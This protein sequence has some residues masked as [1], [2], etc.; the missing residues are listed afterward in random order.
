MCGCSLLKCANLCS[1]PDWMKV[2]VCENKKNNNRLKKIGGVTK[3]LRNW[4]GRRKYLINLFMNEKNEWFVNI[5]KAKKEWCIKIITD[6]IVVW[7]FCFVKV[8]PHPAA[9]ETK[10]HV[11]LNFFFC[12]NQENPQKPRPAEKEEDSSS[13][14]CEII[15]SSE[16]EVIDVS[17]TATTEVRDELI[18]FIFPLKK[19]QT[20]KQLFCY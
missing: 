11:V 5:L 16:C 6:K 14:G 13:S 4:D 2:R 17:S 1:D 12:V 3:N 20:K 18:D 7:F 8:D 15:S 10:K 9:I 19:K